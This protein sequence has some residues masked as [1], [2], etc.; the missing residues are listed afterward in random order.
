MKISLFKVI[1]NNCIATEDGQKIYDIIHP[2][3]RE[4]MVVELDFKN[5]KTF[6]STFFNPAIGHLLK[7][8]DRDNLNKLLKIENLEPTGRSIL[9]RVIENSK[10]Y[11]SNPDA[12]KIID[13]QFL[14][15]TGN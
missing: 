9:E 7:D 3:L 1:G 13:E 11:Y 14:K 2:E 8:I 4:G 15:Q 10:E 5:V 6:A 12:H